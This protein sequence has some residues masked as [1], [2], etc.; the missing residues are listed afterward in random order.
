M[1]L[2][3][4]ITDAISG[5]AQQVQD[6]LGNAG[7]ALGGLL[8]NTGGLSGL[9]EKFNQA[10]L[11]ETVQ[12][13]ISQGENLPISLEQIQSVLGPD[14]LNALAER[15]GV[16]PAQAASW[17]SDNLP[18]W[19]NQLTPDGQLPDVGGLLDQGVAAVKGLF[20]RF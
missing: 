5:G 10:G 6:T 12:S 11:G 16:D 7:G 3:D 17:L 13:W 9:V 2:L 15:V 14:T 8:E 1:G 19:V 20:D 18:E 4:Q